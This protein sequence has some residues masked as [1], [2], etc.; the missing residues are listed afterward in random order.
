MC[1]EGAAAVRHSRAC[2]W[3]A[4]HSHVAKA[5]EVHPQQQGSI[6]SRCP[7]QCLAPLGSWRHG[8]SFQPEGGTGVLAAA[9]ENRE[10]NSSGKGGGAL[11]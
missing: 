2:V 1:A 3:H 10:S 8:S 5:V 6:V 9:W 11:N 7:P 4:T